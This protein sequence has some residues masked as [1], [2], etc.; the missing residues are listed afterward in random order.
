MDKMIVFG[1]PSTFRLGVPPEELWYG[2]GKLGIDT[3]AGHGYY[4]SLVNLTSGIQWSISV[5]RP[6]NIACR[7]LKITGA[8]RLPK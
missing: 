5:T 6:E 2:E 8:S 1:H 4:L 3:G 7:K